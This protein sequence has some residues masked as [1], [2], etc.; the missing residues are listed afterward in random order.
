[1]VKSVISRNTVFFITK[2]NE[3]FSDKTCI[4]PLV[5][6]IAISTESIKKFIDFDLLKKLAIIMI[7]STFALYTYFVMLILQA[8]ANVKNFITQA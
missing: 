5:N 4:I 8:F 1:M 7:L 6:A 3:I 2:L